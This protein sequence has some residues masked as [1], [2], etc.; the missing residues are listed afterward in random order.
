[1]SVGREVESDLRA[2]GRF[3]AYLESRVPVI[4]QGLELHVPAA[5]DP[6]TVLR[7]AMRYSL[8]A[9]GKRLRPAL[10]LLTGELL[11]A[12]T[13]DL[14]PGAVAVECVHTFSLVHDDL[15]AL[16]DDDLRR[17]R[18]TLHHRFGEATAILA[19]DALLARAIEVLATRPAGIP[20]GRRAGAVALVAEAIGLE[21]M[22]GGQMADLEAE[23]AWPEEPAAALDDI[24][25]RKTGALLTVSLRLGALYAE[26]SSTTD[27]ILSRLGDRLGLM[28]QIGDDILDAEGRAEAIGKS[29]GK[30]AALH[31]LTAVELHG[32]AASRERLE[33]LATEAEELVARL[34]CDTT[35]LRSLVDFLVT[36]ET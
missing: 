22:I 33:R 9:G 11:G 13:G 25:R 24:H 19:G 7:Q 35:I 32:V 2:S 1:M 26:A 18:P 27:E 20:A 15:P 8:L 12:E 23:K 10:V 30:D 36:R 16:D 28:F 31:K 3:L 4:E 14:V 6:P 29:P 5:D 34:P 17:G 21:G